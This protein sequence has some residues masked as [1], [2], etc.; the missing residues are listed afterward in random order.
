MR[1]SGSGVREVEQSLSLIDQ[2][3]AQLPEGPICKEVPP[4]G[5]MREGMAI[6]D[7]FAATFWFGCAC[8]MA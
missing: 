2:I 5:E 4:G 8:A 3:L 7:D 1:A 6:V